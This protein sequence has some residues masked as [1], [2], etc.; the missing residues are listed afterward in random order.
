M[1]SDLLNQL[2]VISESC[3]AKV[4]VVVG[5]MGNAKL[6]K[7]L[8]VYKEHNF[9]FPNPSDPSRKVYIVTCIPHCFKNLR[10]N[11]LD[12]KLVYKDPEGKE[13]ILEKSMFERLIRDDSELGDLKLCPKVGEAHLEVQGHDRQRVKF[14]TQL[15]SDTVSK[16][17]LTLY[18]EEYR[19]QAQLISVFDKFFDVMDS[20][21]VKHWKPEKCGFGKLKN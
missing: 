6:L 9:F 4:R 10:N 13:V 3:H 8:K 16:A 19:E 15:L 11:I 18:K 21:T 12:Y 7:Q 1:V 14:A 20:R 2:I 17:L 5:D